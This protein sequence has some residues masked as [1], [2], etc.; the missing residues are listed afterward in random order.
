MSEPLD[1]PAILDEH[2]AKVM[3][4]KAAADYLLERSDVVRAWLPYD[5]RRKLAHVLI[6]DDAPEWR[7][8][9][10][11]PNQDIGAPDGEA[12]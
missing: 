8:D 3:R 2:F 11:A 9:M 10:G 1:D 6:G 12:A 4:L 5:V 7:C